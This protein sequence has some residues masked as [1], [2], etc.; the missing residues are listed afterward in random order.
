MKKQLVVTLFISAFFCKCTFA[1]LQLPALSPKASVMQTVGLTDISI[2]YSSPA[3]K[4]RVIWGDLLP[5]DTLW[6]AGANSATK[7]TFSQDVTI[8]GVS[9]PKGSYSIF[10]IPSKMDWTIIINKNATASEGEYTKQEDLVRAKVKPQMMPLRERL[11]YSI[12]DFND[13]SAMVNMEWEKVRVSFM[14]K[15]GTHEQA[16]ANINS[17]LTPTWRSYNSAARYLLDA[18]KDY[19]TALKWAEQSI[20]LKDEWYNNWIKAQILYAKGMTKDAYTFAQKAK[21]L[22]DKTPDGFFY[23]SQVEKALVDWKGK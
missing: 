14:V 8:E 4:G 13:E 6:R 19:D 9:V 11:A 7:I 23:K 15:L 22:G 1:Q 21:E 17:T 3:V 18:K 12:T 2:D 5:Y 10:I 20:T 16:M